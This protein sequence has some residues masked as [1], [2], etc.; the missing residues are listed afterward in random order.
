MGVGS[1]LQPAANPRNLEQ[2]MKW[3]ENLHLLRGK[4]SALGSWTEGYGDF[5]IVH[6]NGAYV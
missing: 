5:D 1:R 6:Q 3:L 2:I 4:L